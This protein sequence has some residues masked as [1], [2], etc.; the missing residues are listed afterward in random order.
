MSVNPRFLS[1]N[2]IVEFLGGNEDNTLEELNLRLNSPRQEPR[3]LVYNSCCQFLPH[4]HNVILPE[5]EQ[6]E[7]GRCEALLVNLGN[8]DS[9]SRGLTLELPIGEVC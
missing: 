5:F 6:L 3:E 9:Y 1:S 7:H 8:L 4:P 2:E